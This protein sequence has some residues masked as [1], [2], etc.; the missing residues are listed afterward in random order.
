MQNKLIKIQKDSN[1]NFEYLRVQ[2]CF[3]VGQKSYIHA[4]ENASLRDVHQKKG[5]KAYIGLLRF[6][7]NSAFIFLTFG[8]IFRHFRF[9]GHMVSGFCDFSI[10]SFGLPYRARKFVTKELF[11]HTYRKQNIFGSRSA[12]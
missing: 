6:Y 12:S 1:F 9:F 2:K 8:L 4:L 10:L 3:L 11:I 5:Q 7:E